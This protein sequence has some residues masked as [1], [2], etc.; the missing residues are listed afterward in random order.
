MDFLTF[1]LA[2]LCV[3]IGGAV[4]GVAA[5]GLPLVAIPLLTLV[6]GLKTAVALMALPLIGSNL[7]QS[8]QGGGMLTMLRRLWPLAGSVFVCTL[9]G[10]QLLV[11]VPLHLLEGFI[12]VALIVLPI[13]LHF[14]PEVRLSER[15]RIWSDPAM[16]V[17]AGFFGG[18]SAL[19]GPPLM[20]YVLG[21]RL[22]KEEF[23]VAISLL[24]W[25]AG[26]G[27]FLGVYGLGVANLTLLGLSAVMLVPVALGLWLGQLVQV[28]LSEA[29]FHQVLMVVYLATGAS[30][31]VQAIA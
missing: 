30:F 24:Y 23:V 12:G 4:K 1:G 9:L 14:R 29:R 28:K 31:L 16:G 26:L 5:L 18:I 8:L 22:P 21:M 19:Y 20:L 27:L 11:A 3:F 17:F 25:I 7:I 10:T 13:Y 2:A 15:H 6:V